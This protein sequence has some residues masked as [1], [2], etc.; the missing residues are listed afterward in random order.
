MA[1]VLDGMRIFAKGEFEAIELLR[2]R[3]L[4]EAIRDRDRL[5]TMLDEANIRLLTEHKKHPISLGVKCDAE[6]CKTRI[7][8][9]SSDDI[10]PELHGLAILQITTSLRWRLSCLTTKSF[11]DEAIG[12]GE[13]DLCPIH[14]AEMT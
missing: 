9:T 7:A 6:R 3:A 13:L 12:I 5:Q 8:V 14:A 11:D 2:S 10:S 4:S 1:E